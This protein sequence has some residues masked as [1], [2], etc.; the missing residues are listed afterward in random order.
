MRPV[1]A[2]HLVDHG[3]A[4]LGSVVG[5]LV[6]RGALPGSVAQHVVEVPRPP[7]GDAKGD[8]QEAV[9]ASPVIARP[10][11]PAM[12]S[13]VP[14]K[15]SATPPKIQKPIATRIPVPMGKIGAGADVIAQG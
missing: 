15:R 10:A 6:A 4:N 13:R 3:L 2:Y 9:K 11:A 12:T 14:P 1:V 7:C 5:V 8:Q